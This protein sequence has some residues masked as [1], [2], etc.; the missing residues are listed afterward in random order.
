MAAAREV[1]RT[2]D[3]RREQCDTHNIAIRLVLFER[4]SLP[5]SKTFPGARQPPVEPGPPAV[6][7]GEFPKKLSKFPSMEVWKLLQS[8]LWERVLVGRPGDVTE[9]LCV[10][11]ALLAGER[12]II[13]GVYLGIIIAG[14]ESTE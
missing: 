7:P 12:V 6:S 10:G 3:S 8:M 14:G 9:P 5:K 13:D 2:A 1:S 4:A 11:G